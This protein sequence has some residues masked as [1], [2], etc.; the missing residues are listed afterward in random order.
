MAAL[1]VAGWAM[2]S[3]SRERSRS[4][5][6]LLPEGFEVSRPAQGDEHGA[7]AGYFDP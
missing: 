1:G 4:V 3:K 5:A 2:P 7:G 6:R